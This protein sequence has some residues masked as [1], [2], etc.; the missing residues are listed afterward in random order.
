MLLFLGSIVTNTLHEILQYLHQY[1]SDC[2]TTV[3]VSPSHAVWSPLRFTYNNKDSRIIISRLL[4]FALY[5]I[6]EFSVWWNNCTLFRTYIVSWIDTQNFQRIFF[7]FFAN[8]LRIRDK[9]FRKSHVL[10]IKLNLFICIFKRHTLTRIQRDQIN[11][12]N[13]L[14][15][16]SNGKDVILLN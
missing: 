3:H 10:D 16:V 8:D 15:L 7:F 11:D 6:F 9:T 5:N 2:I 14:N 12:Q 13:K 1:R 4:W